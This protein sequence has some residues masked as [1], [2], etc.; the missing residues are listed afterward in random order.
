MAGARKLQRKRLY[1]KASMALPPGGGEPDDDSVESSSKSDNKR[2]KKLSRKRSDEE[3]KFPREDSEEEE[4]SVV[5]DEDDG[6]LMDDRDDTG[7]TTSGD[8]DD[9]AA[10][11]K[12]WQG[13]VAEKKKEFDREKRSVL[14]QL[15]QSYRNRFGEVGFGRFGKKYY[16]AMILGPYDVPSGAPSFLR[17][18]W[19]GAFEKV[20]RRSR[21][22]VGVEA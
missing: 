16:P 5:D 1:G 10:E 17:E 11:L 20:L 8:D 12:Q 2:S 22:R 15:P 21:R 7:D 13:M 9:A 14:D 3:D 6:P 18:T 4:G 19:M